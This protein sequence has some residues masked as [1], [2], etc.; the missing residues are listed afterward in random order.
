MRPGRLLLAALVAVLLLVAGAAVAL[1]TLDLGGLSQP[2]I[3]R[4]GDELRRPL[5]VD[6]PVSIRAGRTLRLSAQGIRL[7]NVAWG[8]RGDMLR[9]GRLT[10]EIDAA[11]L[12]NRPVI[13]RRIEVDGLDL[14][15]ERR[16]DGA[17]N[18]EFA[19]DSPD[20]KFTWPE[21]LPVVVDSV[22]VPGARIRFM[23]PRLDRP[24]DLRFDRLEQH[25]GAG[26]MLQ[27]AAQG[28]ANDEPLSVDMTAGPFAQLVAGRDFSV[29][30]DGR[31]GEL[32]L[33]AHLRVDD[34]ARPVKT[35]LD[36]KVRGPGAAYLTSR[37]GVRNLGSGPLTLDALVRPS[38]DGAGVEGELT[39]EIGQFTIK[40]RGGLA[41]PAVMSRARAELEVAGP[42][43]SFAGG[44]AGIDRLPAE[45]FRLAAAIDRAGEKL[46][47]DDATLTVA[48][49]TAS[50]KGT[51]A[52]Y[53]ALRGNDLEFRFRGAD[54]GRFRGFLSLPP[55]L[56]G[57]F[58]IS[59]TL[60]ASEG[61]ELVDVSATTVLGQATLSGSLG[62]SP[63]FHGTRLEVAA[64]GP[65]LARVG[66]VAGLKRLPGVDFAATAGVEWTAG[67]TMI[68]R[69]Q[70]RG[71]RDQLGIEG[72]VARRPL[73]PGTDLT[74]SLRG[75][76]LRQLAAG[77]RIDGVPDGA[78]DLRGRLRRE[79]R[80]S[81]LDDVQ[82]TIAGATLRLS[83]R[84]A[85]QPKL[86]TTLDLAVEGPR[87][88][89]FASLVPGYRLP[90]GEFRVAGGLAV[91]PK[92]V[93]LNRMQLAAAGA[94]GTVD[95]NIELPLS[96]V[97]GEFVVA[98][99]GRDVTRFLPRLGPARVAPVPFDLRV[100]GQAQGGAWRLDE[101]EFSTDAGR[102]S[103]SGRLDWAPDFSATALKVTASSRDL[104]V[105]GRLFGLDLPAQPFELT[106]EFTG[107][108]TAF[109]VEKAT[110]RLGTTDFDGTL[111]LGLGKRTVLDVDFGSELLDLTPFLDEPA[112][113]AAAAAAAPPGPARRR[114]SPRLIPDT[115]IPLGWL[116]RLDGSL[117]VRAS[118][119]LF[120][121]VALDDLRM[122]AR[123]KDGAL[124]LD[125][126]E[127]KAPPDGRLSL[128][129]R[130]EKRARGAAMQLAA[131]G[132]R[133]RLAR[134]EDTPAVRNARPRAELALELTGEGA[135]W[136]ELAQSLDGG[137]SLT[138]GAGSIPARNLD[139]LFGGLWR[140]LVTTVIPGMASRETT[141]VRCMAAFVTATGGVLRTAPAVVL[142]TERVN[143]ITHGS[144][145]LG[146]EQLEIFLN[147]APRRGRVDV[148]VAEIVNPYLKV[149]GTLA[150]PGVGVD[151]K[152][153]LFTGG[154]AVA[155]AGISILAK[156]VWDRMF[157][158]EDPCA[159][160]AAEAERLESG[161][162]AP[163]K[164]LIP[165][166]GSRR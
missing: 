59:G 78:F 83:G 148:T 70:L 39:G 14:L 44:L 11:S 146:K 15:L 61:A 137:A 79:A 2:L 133:V 116:D 124:A 72:L 88:E 161:E 86:G 91:T 47:I 131:S 42:D 18:W 3:R 141:S 123:L 97:R 165:W 138:T 80:A 111:Q 150:D 75:P 117:A 64:S 105:A 166:S 8:S 84:V 132:T 34:V 115:P 5:A 63:D 153:V 45:P 121:T 20:A 160:A 112:P 96:A 127:M 65:S 27:L 89:S 46:R 24:L 76:N 158:A 128:N 109:R 87:L 67:G 12:I 119:A 93:T 130:I 41:D 57:D 135:T 152:G 101:A 77:F 36:L 60:R 74:W 33:I 163:R 82:G 17:S 31:L 120:A 40:A 159:V 48:D 56:G 28:A 126:L 21:S 62:A 1:F 125:S 108:P 30:L 103:G 144:V 51:V 157:R 155:T 154:A 29:G 90:P 100:R 92:R 143:I 164:T 19:P 6:G 98:A 71:G 113:A 49:A 147:T 134:L 122:T 54:L 151:P 4:A 10:V 50:L 136:R 94:Q 66:E 110:G 149:T 162:E 129:G 140:D 145:D 118:R 43:L 85:D 107:T 22:S 55:S 58:D 53:T 139:L 68:R 7:A 32:N 73:G 102:V 81:R 13:V 35:L 37:F 99:K 9:V 69:G 106:A 26:G 156:G 16:A 114:A 52:Q 95:A 25:R 23:G 142:Q 38:A 104:S